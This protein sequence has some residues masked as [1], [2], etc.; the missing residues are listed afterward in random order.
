MNKKG[1]AIE[2]CKKYFEMIH[3][4]PWVIYPENIVEM[5]RIYDDLVRST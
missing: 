4:A 1:S 2:Y 3:I 5:K